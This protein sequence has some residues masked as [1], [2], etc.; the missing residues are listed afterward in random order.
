MIFIYGGELGKYLL[1]EEGG[2]TGPRL[3]GKRAR[4]G[5]GR[6]IQLIFSTQ[7][8]GRLF[9]FSPP[10]RSELINSSKKRR[11]DFEKTS[12]FFAQ[13]SLQGFVYIAAN[14]IGRP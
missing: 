12:T 7:G 1:S 2:L 8:Y 4:R 9:V 3:W 14:R 11:R 10:Q 13:L 5:C 6:T